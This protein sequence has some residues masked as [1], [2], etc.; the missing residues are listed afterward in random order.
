MKVIL[1]SVPKSGTYLMSN[2]FK[3]LG[4]ESSNFHFNDNEY[5]DYSGAAMDKA[6]TNPESFRVEEPFEKGI[7]RL[8]EGQFA[9]GHFSTK[10]LMHLDGFEKLFI[11][12]DLTDCIISFAIWTQKTGRWEKADANPNWR[13]TIDQKDFVTQFL[14]QHGESVKGLFAKTVN[15]VDAPNVVKVKSETLRGDDGRE[16]QVSEFKKIVEALKLNLEDVQVESKIANALNKRSLTKINND[17]DYDWYKTKEFY[18]ELDKL[19]ILDLNA[20]MGYFVQKTSF[21]ERIGLKKSLS[22]YD[23]Y[24]RKNKK[25]KNTWNYGIRIVDNLIENYTFNTVLDAGCG[26]A[27]V[28]RY[29]LSKGYKAKGIELSGEVLKTHAP[30]LLR[31]R[32]VRQG[33]LTKLPFKDNAFDVVFSSEVLEHIPEKDI[34]Q[35][36]AEL[37]RVAKH[38]VFTTISLRPS[39]SFNKYHITLKPRA[40]WEEQFVN[41]GLELDSEMQ[42]RFQKQEAG[43]TNEEVLQIGPTKTHIHEMEWF[44]EDHPYDFNGELEPWYFIFKNDG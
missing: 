2:F 16:Q 22:F 31:R 1:C 13:N 40:W 37:K 6:R 21:L 8:L 43:L 9:V 38:A 42:D 12:R 14:K 36:A 17:Q 19:G 7:K 18:R 34:P 10:Q 35:V 15:W 41:T 29:L 4:L 20:R 28:V 23:Q 24:W 3:E 5:S 27:D 11:Y 32:I 33:S 44:I 26:S 30:D 39:S 25:S